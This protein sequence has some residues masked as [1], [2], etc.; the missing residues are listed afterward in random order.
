M[1]TPCISDKC[2]LYPACKNKQYIKCHMLNLHISELIKV[3]SNKKLEHVFYLHVDE[4]QILWAKL[5]ET[6]PSLKIVNFKDYKFVDPCE[7]CYELC[8][9]NPMYSEVV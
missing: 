2:L 1:N 6:F 7:K 3:I 9:I 8:K 5:K 4:Q